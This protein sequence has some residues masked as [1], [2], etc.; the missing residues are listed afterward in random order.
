[1]ANIETEIIDQLR[2]M[3][4]KNLP[5]SD[6]LKYLDSKGLHTID[7]ITSFQTA[8]GLSF[9]DASPIGGWFAD[10]TGELDDDKIHK[11]LATVI[12]YKRCEWD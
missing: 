5:A 7:M 2:D 1:M 3:W 10:G 11:L 4:R 12:D 8:F 6:L 9:G